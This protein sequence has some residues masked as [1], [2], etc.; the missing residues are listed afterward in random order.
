MP[1]TE[2]HVVDGGL[3]VR[4]SVLELRAS[5]VRDLVPI[6][7]RVIGRDE[8]TRAVPVAALPRIRPERASV[9]LS[10]PGAR[11]VNRGNA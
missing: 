9:A 10:L 1:I 8:D 3:P 4:I 6:A 11:A 5:L 2:Q 7:L